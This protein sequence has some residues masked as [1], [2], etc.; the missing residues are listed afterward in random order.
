MA[1][2][3]KDLRRMM[4]VESRLDL[5]VFH[6]KDK[7]ER[8]WESLSDRRSMKKTKKKIFFSMS[9]RHWQCSE[10]SSFSL[11]IGRD[12]NWLMNSIPMMLR[13]TPLFNWEM[14]RRKFFARAFLSWSKSISHQ[15]KRI[16]LI[17]WD[18]LQVQSNDFIG[19]KDLSFFL[20][21]VNNR[22]A[23]E[24]LIDLLF[25]RSVWFSS[26]KMRK[27]IL[28]KGDKKEK[29]W[30]FLLFSFIDKEKKTILCGET[31]LFLFEEAF[32]CQRNPF[33]F[34][35]FFVRGTEF[36]WV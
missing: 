15:M 3:L 10:F 18:F 4:K 9:N 8:H 14:F 17:N 16:S 24:P 13:E 29:N 1:E 2:E 27:E 28:Q 25:Y 12:S 33:L 19:K 30:P 20:W 7:W 36:K 23:T 6:S 5:N 31:I 22:L 26:L 32:T 35:F 34:F 21:T 11:Q